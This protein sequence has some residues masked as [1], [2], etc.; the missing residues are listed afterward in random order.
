MTRRITDKGI[1]ALKPRAKRYEKPLGSGLYAV[2]QPSGRKGYAIR[3]KMGGRSRKLTLA[4]VSL[5][6]AR[7]EAANALYEVQQGKDPAF[8]KQQAKQAAR[9]AGDETFEAIAENY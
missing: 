3:Y 2:V 4:G 8:A 1:Q 7:R 6:A 9:L 5:A